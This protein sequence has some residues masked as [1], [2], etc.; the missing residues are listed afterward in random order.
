[1]PTFYET[2]QT[3]YGEHAD[4]MQE[5]LQEGTQRA[6]TLGNRG[7]IKF[8]GDGS[9]HPDIQQA[10]E[11]CGFYIFENVL[12]ADELNDIER[13]VIAMW[14]N[15]PV[16]KGADK[17][18]FGRPALGSS[19]QSRSLSWVK[20]LSDPIG[21]TAVSHG[22]HP[23][24]MIEP[25][26]PSDAPDHILQLVLGSLQFSDA[27]L[28]VYAHPQLL[29][30]AAAINGDDFV[31]FNEAVWMKHPYLGGSVAWHQDGFTHWQNP[32]LDMHTH[33]FNFMA[34]LYGC[35]AA[36]GLWVLPG[37][38]DMGKVDIKALVEAQGSDR[39]A[40]A[41]P[42][43]CA[44]GDVAIC[45]R[46][47]VHGSFANTSEN[48]RVTINFGFHQRKSVLGVKGGGIH[49]D[50]TVY[51]AGYIDE[52]SRMIAYGIQARKQRFP[53]EEAFCY[54]PLKDE[55]EKFVWHES[56]REKIKD[57]NLKDLGI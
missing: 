12:A 14:E 16:H 41:V 51:D 34:Q 4:A 10:Y 40:D 54:L 33:G 15:A 57:Y 48:M 24:K 20:P 27:C 50:V 3:S 32:N 47:A 39:L 28:R 30:V 2:A 35:D 45:N 46:Q 5:Y 6:L 18:Q 43:I 29:K 38:H 13:D 22:R 8:A 11:R 26:A 31:P 42:F 55:M 7:P 44:A 52:R 19:V 56:A 1:M 9:L 17:D 23:A 25:T 49:N 53:Q 36:N 21:G 37:S